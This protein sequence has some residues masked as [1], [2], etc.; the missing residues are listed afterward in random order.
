MILLILSK[1][2]GDFAKLHN[3]R[4]QSVK[5]AR[6]CQAC[7]SF[8]EHVGCQRSLKKFFEDVARE[9]FEKDVIIVEFEQIW[10]RFC[11]IT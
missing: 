9:H 4:K 11:K 3:F 2:R 5:M 10:R 7:R 8:W 1:Y 6:E